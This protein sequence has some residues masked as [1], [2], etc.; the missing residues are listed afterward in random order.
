[1]PSV[2]S[3]NRPAIAPCEPVTVAHRCVQLSLL[4]DF[5]IGHGH[6]GGRLLRMARAVLP[7]CVSFPSALIAD[8]TALLVFAPNLILRRFDNS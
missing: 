4:V 3:L 7:D 2:A 5:R 6:T 8:P 1:M